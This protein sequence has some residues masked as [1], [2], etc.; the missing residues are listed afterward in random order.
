MPAPFL[1]APMAVGLA[2]M[3]SPGTD[4]QSLSPPAGQ[5][6]ESASPMLGALEPPSEDL[7]LDPP[8]AHQLV[9][10]VRVELECFAHPDGRIDGC[11]VVEEPRPGLGFSE[12]AIALMEGATLGDEI[13]KPRFGPVRFRHTIDFTPN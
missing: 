12:A 5:P 13:A 9:P 7:T 4:P 3:G 6:L 2:L 10:G 11:R 1:F 8:T